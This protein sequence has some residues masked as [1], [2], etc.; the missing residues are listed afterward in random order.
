MVPAVGEHQTGSGYQVGD[1]AGH[2]HLTRLCPGGDLLRDMN[3]DTGELVAMLFAFSGV[4]AGTNLE[5]E[6]PRGL[7]GCESALHSPRWAIEGDEE[8]LACRPHLSSTEPREF[9]PHHL[10][11]V[12]DGCPPAHVVELVC[13]AARIDKT[14]AQQRCQDAV[15]LGDSVRTGQEFLDLVNQPIDVADEDEVILAGELH[16][17]RSWD[18]IGEVSPL[19]DP[20]QRIVSP[21]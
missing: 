9:A 2:E 16:I 10:V 8:P 19:L 15:G 4:N 1:R 3:R 18:V 5:A 11:V 20:S 12:T 17:L 7:C 21:M 14:Q 13:P 6:A